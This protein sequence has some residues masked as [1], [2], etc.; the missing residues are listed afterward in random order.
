MKKGFTL[1]ELMAVIVILAIIAAIAFPFIQEAIKN[2]REKACEE[3]KQRIESAAERWAAD[4]SALLQGKNTSI[5]ISNLKKN[6]YLASDQE[7]NNPAN[8]EEMTG[9]VTLKYDATYKQYEYIYDI[10]C[11]VK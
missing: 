4:N 10:D 7:L 9:S 5:S 11:K 1:I 2:S 6:G 8:N 3:Q